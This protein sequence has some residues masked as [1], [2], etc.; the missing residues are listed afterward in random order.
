MQKHNRQLVRVLRV[1]V[2]PYFYV[3]ERRLNGQS[4]THIQ[5]LST[6]RELAG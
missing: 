5:M 4:V 6:R 1:A 3:Q 2:S